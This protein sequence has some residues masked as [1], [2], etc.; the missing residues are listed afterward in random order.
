MPSRYHFPN[1][2]GQIVRLQTIAFE[3]PPHKQ[4]MTNRRI[5]GRTPQPNNHMLD[6]LI[7][8][9]SLIISRSVMISLSDASMHVANKAYNLLL[10]NKS[11]FFVQRY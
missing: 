9:Y 11:P 5:G 4:L 3:I 6:H 10:V 1:N 8:T 2:Q 7:L